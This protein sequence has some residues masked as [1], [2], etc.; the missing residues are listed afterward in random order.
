[1]QSLRQLKAQRLAEIAASIKQQ[2]APEEQ[3]RLQDGSPV[4]PQGSEAALAAASG[5]SS[6]VSTMDAL[7]ALLTPSVPSLCEDSSCS[8]DGVDIMA[9]E[10]RAC[11]ANGFVESEA[12]CQRLEGAWTGNNGD[13]YIVEARK[14]RIVRL[15][16][17]KGKR[18]IRT[19]RMSWDPVRR[20]VLWANTL[21]AVPAE[22]VHCD[23]SIV[24]Y[25][26]ANVARR[27][28]C[29]MWVRASQ[30]TA[31]LSLQR[32]RGRCA[33]DGISSARPVGASGM[34]D[35]TFL[36]RMRTALLS[37]ELWHM[38]AATTHLQLPTMGF[39]DWKP[40]TALP[41]YFSWEHALSAS[42]LLQELG[43]HDPV[44]A[45]ILESR[46]ETDVN[47]DGVRR[48]W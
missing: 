46:E 23:R 16:V 13:C 15:S 20:V 33:A 31:A 43:F 2:I 10:P 1:M 36:L 27:C 28:F 35:R 34:Y 26:S 48:K 18:T 21:F 9:S 37:Q 41:Q 3:K 7:S 38:H 45:G 47:K 22:L 14:S 8:D 42:I 4:A 12:A 30:D 24:W 11:D 39:D 29:V 44:L 25:A 17:R 5:I 40:Y 32:Y 19:Y 6:E